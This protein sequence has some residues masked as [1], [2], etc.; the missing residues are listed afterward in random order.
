MLPAALVFDFDGVIA[1]SEPLHLV[2][3][4]EV[5]ATVGIDLSDAEYYDRYLGFDDEGAFGA[6]LEARGRAVDPATVNALIE[7]KALLLPR[8]LSAP[9]V[10]VPGAAAC[11]E[12]AAASMPLAIASGA[13]RDEIELVLAAN[14]LRDHFPVIVAAGETPRFKPHPDPY[15]TAVAR[16]VAAGRLRP[17]TAP[18][19]CVA[20]EDSRWGIES[21]QAAG[22]RCIA[23]TTSYPREALARADHVVDGLDALTPQLLAAV[24]N[25]T[26]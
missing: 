22:L 26:C 21:A 6:I 10:L 14:G 16:L 18:R 25:G 23:L 19:H 5:L 7:A 2:A 1:N 12:R 13:R 8:M 15:A 3:F 20:I 24:V 9:D 17:E 4:R 11:I